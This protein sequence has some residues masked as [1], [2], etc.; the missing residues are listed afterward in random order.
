MKK[1]KRI[2]VSLLTL[3]VVCS[4]AVFSVSAADHKLTIYTEE[5]PPYNFKRGGQVSGIASDLLVEMFKKMD[6]SY[7]RNS[8]KIVPWARAYN[9]I[10][11]QSNVMVYSMTRT[12]ERENMFKW[13]GPIINSS[14][15]LI[16]KKSTDIS[17]SG[18]SSYNDYTYTAVRQD[19]GEKI[20][21]QKGVNRSKISSTASGVSCAK[22][23]SRGRVQMWVYEETTAMWYLKSIGENTSDYKVVKVLDK[24]Q[25]YFAFSKDVPNSV[26]QKYQNALNR[27]KKDG[28][29]N[30]VV[31]KY[32]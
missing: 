21:G 26:I 28:S 7:T 16:A 17:I 19:V 30:S 8:I 1:I 12:K 13:V 15:V 32:R 25:L 5:Y 23:L 10:Q 6:S 18:N 20:L 14:N 27:C 2:M 3:V 9:A 29:Y 31:R 11:K 24:S 22:M 4:S